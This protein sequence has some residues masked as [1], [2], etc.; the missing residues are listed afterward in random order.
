MTEKE[1]NKLDSEFNS[2]LDIWHGGDGDKAIKILKNLDTQF[3]NT[4]SILGMIGAIYFSL[5]DWKHSEYY[6]KRTIEIS[7]KSELASLGLFHSLWEMKNLDKAFEEAKRFVSMN[8]YSS[9][10]Q[11]LPK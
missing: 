2:A 4:P 10:Y 1:K 6:F 3:P 7:P 8:G 9:K 5:R 11:L